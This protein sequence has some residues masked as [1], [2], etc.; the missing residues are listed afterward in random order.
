MY[1][2]GL[3][4]N[5]KREEGSLNKDWVI[6]WEDIIIKAGTLSGRSEIFSNLIKVSGLESHV[7]SLQI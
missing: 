1:I 6:P 3:L 2:L 7:P 5:L 4:Q